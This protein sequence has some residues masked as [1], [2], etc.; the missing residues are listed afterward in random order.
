[1][2]DGTFIKNITFAEPQ[3][4]LDLVD[5]Q[6]GRVISRTLAQNSAMSLTL[7]AFDTGEGLSTHSAGGDAF[8]HILDGEAQIT[9]DA[10]E[11]SVKAGQV[12]VM[13]ANVPH[14]VHATQRFKM[15]LVVVK[16][17]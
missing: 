4:L 10:R 9:I 12:I 1:M 14:A 17:N 7:F 3:S 8:V 11:N 15:L 16:G 6:E 13:P 5:Y 2:K